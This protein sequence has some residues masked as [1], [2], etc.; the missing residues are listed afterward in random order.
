[1][2]SLVKTALLL[3]LSTTSALADACCS[4]CK[5]GDTCDSLKPKIAQPQS[6]YPQLL[7]FVSFSMPMETLK[8]LTAQVNAIGGAVVFRGLLGGSF[9]GI[10]LKLKELGQEALID[11]TLFEA[12]KVTTVPTFILRKNPT[13]VA[14][15]N[16]SHDRLSGNVSLIHVLEQFATQGDV[17]AVAQSLLT[18][19][20][21][22]PWMGK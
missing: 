2:L 1:M 3:A 12:Y 20:R 18:K 10:V 21:E 22:K 4:S 9:K 7:V 19:L 6:R 17:R 11:P 16:A 14:R 5:Q 8:I 15:P 13:E